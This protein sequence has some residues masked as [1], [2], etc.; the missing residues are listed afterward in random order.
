LEASGEPHGGPRSPRP[1]PLSAFAPQPLQ[2]D[3]LLDSAGPSPKG[4]PSGVGPQYAKC[5]R[6]NSNPCGLWSPGL[7]LEARS[8]V[9]QSA[10]AGGLKSLFRLAEKRTR[11]A[12]EKG[13]YQVPT[14]RLM[15]GQTSSPAPSSP[16]LPLSPS[17]SSS[18]RV[19]D[20]RGVMA[21]RPQV[22]WFGRA[23]IEMALKDVDP[24]M[25]TPPLIVTDIS[26]LDVAQRL[27]GSNLGGRHV[28]MLSE[29]VAFDEAG[30]I[31]LTQPYS[32]HPH[33][34]PVRTDIARYFEEAKVSVRTGLSD[35]R[36][37][38]TAKQ[39]PYIFVSPDV[40]CFRGPREDGYPFSAEPYR[41][42]VVI[43]A[44]ASNRPAIQA[45]QGR[46]EKTKWYA[47]KT[48]HMALV[49]RLN[50]IGMAALQAAGIDGESM[51]E[52]EVAERAP[53]L[54]LSAMGFGGGDQFHP[55]DAFA[56]C[57][58]A[59]RKRFSNFFHSVF[60]CCTVR[61]N[62]DR[63]HAER[64]DQIVNKNVFRMT[65]ND[66]LARR[67]WPWH[68]DVS[69]IC[70][71]VSRL[72]LEAA[73]TRRVAA[74]AAALGRRPCSESSEDAAVPG[75][76]GEKVK[77]STMSEA[78][79]NDDES[80]DREPPETSAAYLHQGFTPAQDKKPTE[81]T[82][83]IDSAARNVGVKPRKLTPTG[84]AMKDALSSMKMK[85]ARTEPAN[86]G[87]RKTDEKSDGKAD[88][89]DSDDSF[90]EEPSELL[91]ASQVVTVDFSHGEGSTNDFNQTRST[92]EPS[93]MAP[94]IA[95]LASP[96]PSGK[97]SPQ[98]RRASV[99]GLLKHCGRRLSSG[100]VTFGEATDG[101]AKSA[102][103][104]LVKLDLEAKWK[105]AMATRRQSLAQTVGSWDTNIGG[106]GGGGG[107]G[108]GAGSN[109]R[110]VSFLGNRAATTVEK[111]REA[112]DERQE[113]EI[114]R[115][116]REQLMHKP[117]QG[118]IAAAAAQAVVKHGED[119]GVL[120]RRRAS[121]RASPGTGDGASVSHGGRHRRASHRVDFDRSL[122]APS[123][124]VGSETGAGDPHHSRR[125]SLTAFDRQVA[126]EVAASMR[127]GD[128]EDSSDDE[129]CVGLAHHREQERDEE[130]M[131]EVR[132]MDYEVEG[133]ATS[134]AQRLEMG[135]SATTK[136]GAAKK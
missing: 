60:V 9:M 119:P 71:S 127:V 79:D 82:L 19:V 36:E 62:P 72:R 56:S 29:V 116:V 55:T 27:R 10:N 68:W 97:S 81:A 73:A 108:P 87:R 117:T 13:S 92:A 8:E 118:A 111:A 3:G 90:G 18:S 122:G 38:L 26:P 16:A 96:A 65:A 39:D 28:F 77:R 52:E 64:I 33:C 4:S 136:S 2:T 41:L 114:R 115:R 58:K 99:V 93:T 84:A 109:A 14:Q 69:H 123:T 30:G 107:G 105:G 76:D 15:R 70:L 120:A 24:E 67:A 63:E 78:L 85:K 6:D 131:E 48:D 98:G 40:A 35:I 132:D 106:G 54:I 129:A 75:A 32:V 31:D 59:W 94:D 104:S 101:G 23:N 49:E 5:L 128:W 1:A 51:D 103:H 112:Q 102:L 95:E 113:L 11:T 135:R 42:H 45:V 124:T 110:R 91:S 22:H 74:R 57:L 12:C 100:G 80:S 21:N 50:L 89:S 47:C 88:I 43:S 53:V 126:A 61:G 121:G 37:H 125:K 133:L 20:L 66:E 17:S 7:F 46:V 134:F 83:D 130:F 34:L 44:M 25:I 86:R